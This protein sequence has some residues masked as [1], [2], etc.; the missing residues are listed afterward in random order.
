MLEVPWHA[1]VLWAKANLKLK[2]PG[3]LRW[4]KDTSRESKTLEAEVPSTEVLFRELL[5]VTVSNKRAIA[6]GTACFVHCKQI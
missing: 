2:C 6:R 1:W 3:R 4:P 5:I